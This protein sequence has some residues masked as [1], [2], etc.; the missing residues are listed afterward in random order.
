MRYAAGIATGLALALYFRTR[1]WGRILE[2][3]FTADTRPPRRIKRAREHHAV[4]VPGLP[5]NV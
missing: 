4:R 3:I 1:H 5:A 2:H